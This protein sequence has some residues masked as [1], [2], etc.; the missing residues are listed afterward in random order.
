M[1]RCWCGEEEEE[2]FRG[3]GGGR[4][5]LLGICVKI[6]RCTSARPICGGA[7]CLASFYYWYT[8]SYYLLLQL[9]VYTHFK[10]RTNSNEH[11]IL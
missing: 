9:R 11:Y 10:Q 1:V 5:Q 7:W 8:V 4:R 3:G 6:K 2:E